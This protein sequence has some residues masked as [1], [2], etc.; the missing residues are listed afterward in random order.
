[1][2]SNYDAIVTNPNPNGHDPA[3]IES[4]LAG[5]QGNIVEPHRRGYAVHVKIA[6]KP[7]GIAEALDWIA[8]FNP[9]NALQQHSDRAAGN[10]TIFKMLA[11]IEPALAST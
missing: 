11:L 10:T 6:F 2:A 8:A 9:T 1:M 3:T 5:I 7:N 4:F